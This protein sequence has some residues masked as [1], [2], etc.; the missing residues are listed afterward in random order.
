NSNQNLIHRWY[1][2]QSYSAHVRIPLKIPQEKKEEPHAY[3]SGEQ[4]EQHRVA[5]AVAADDLPRR[6]AVRFNREAILQ[7]SDLGQDFCGGGISCSGIAAHGLARNG[8]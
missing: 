4:P 1:L 5:L 7:P 2:S 3:V 6:F 8:G